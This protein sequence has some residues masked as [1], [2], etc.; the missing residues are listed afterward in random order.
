MSFLPVKWST[1]WI[2]CL[3]KIITQNS[4]LDDRAIL[5][6]NKWKLNKTFAGTLR[7]LGDTEETYQFKNKA[8]LPMLM[9]NPSWTWKYTAL[10]HKMLFHARKPR[11][12]ERLGSFKLFQAWLALQNSHSKPIDFSKEHDKHYRLK[13]YVKPSSL[14]NAWSSLDLRAKFNFLISE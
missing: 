2:R 13:K 9:L 8:R 10:A 14:R 12:F 7:F 11:D 4:S 1:E 5:M 3:Q 6:S